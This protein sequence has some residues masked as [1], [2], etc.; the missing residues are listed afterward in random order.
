[1]PC[2]HPSAHL[3]VDLQLWWMVGSLH[4][5]AF[6]LSVG[7]SLFIGLSV[8]SVYCENMLNLD[9]Q[10]E[11]AGGCIFPGAASTN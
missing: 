2:P 3:W 4:H 6:Y 9:V 10:T 1:M 5:T 8:L 7:T 11:N